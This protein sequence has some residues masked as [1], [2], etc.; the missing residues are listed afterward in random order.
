M[1]ILLGNAIG[2]QFPNF[3]VDNDAA[4]DSGLQQVYN[5]LL[6]MAILGSALITP[7][8]CFFKAKPPHPPRFVFI[9]FCLMLIF[10][11]SKAAEARKLPYLKSLKILFTDSSTLFLIIGASLL[12]GTNMTIAA[13]LQF[14]LQPYGFTNV[15][16]NT[17][18]I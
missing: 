7:S 4:G 16:F 9:S 1:S 2:A 8:F 11:Y 18:N 3:F 5:M 15:N 6:F 10:L 17:F 13:V 14:I 12:F